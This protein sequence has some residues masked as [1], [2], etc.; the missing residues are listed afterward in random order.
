MLRALLA[1]LL[2]SLIAL[3]LRAQHGTAP[4]GYYPKS[5]SGDIFTGLLEASKDDPQRF[6]LVYT[7]GTKSERFAGKLESAC[8]WKSKDGPSHTFNPFEAPPGTVLTAFYRPV[9]RKSG[10]Q[11]STENMVIAIS[12]A[13]INGKKISDERRVTISCSADHF[14]DFMAF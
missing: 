3:P 8:I 13:E 11:K 5:Y 9:S 14:F 10:G 1:F 6:T 4:N 2:S 7:K 12:V